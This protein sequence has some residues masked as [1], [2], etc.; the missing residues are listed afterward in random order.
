MS[1]SPVPATPTR[2]RRPPRCCTAP[3]RSRSAD[4][5]TPARRRFWGA[6][7]DF[8][9]PRSVD[10]EIDVFFYGYGDK[11][12]RDWWEALVGEPSRALPDAD[13]A[14]GGRDFRGDVGRTRQIGDVPFNA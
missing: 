14:L 7:P 9:S 10:K 2:G 5:A 3:R 8:F 1:R 6:E 12:R 11:F 13:F 4:W